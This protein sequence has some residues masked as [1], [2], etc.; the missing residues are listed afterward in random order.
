MSFYR[1]SD[2]KKRDAMVEDYI[3]TSKRLRERSLDEK[4]GELTYVVSYTVWKLGASI[5][6]L[7]K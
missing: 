1:I 5:W 7:H 3:A 4:L 2:P 6:H